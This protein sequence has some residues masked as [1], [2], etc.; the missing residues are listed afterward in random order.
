MTK[1]M[2]E[3]PKGWSE[4]FDSEVSMLTS[5]IFSATRI[6]LRVMQNSRIPHG[7][8]GHIFIQRKHPDRY[9]TLYT[10]DTPEVAIS[11]L[12]G[13]ESAISYIRLKQAEIYFI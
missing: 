3:M 10:F 13:F 12:C 8:N 1:P 4:F 5:N 9:S 11:W 2:D 7:Q 6:S